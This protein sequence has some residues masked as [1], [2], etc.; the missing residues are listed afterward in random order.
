LPG[1]FKRWGGAGGEKGDIGGVHPR[2]KIK[3][4][5]PEKKIG[6]NGDPD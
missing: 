4:K 5:V 6:P 1:G 2:G 3:T